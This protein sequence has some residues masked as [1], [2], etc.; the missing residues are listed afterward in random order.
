MSYYGGKTSNVMNG[1]SPQLQLLDSQV[2]NKVE[3]KYEL[4][5]EAQEILPGKFEFPL[6]QDKNLGIIIIGLIDRLLIPSFC[7]LFYL[8]L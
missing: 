6:Q 7:V 2:D 8:L 3:W 5:R 4:R 1:I